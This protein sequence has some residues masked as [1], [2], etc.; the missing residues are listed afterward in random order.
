MFGGLKNT[1]AAAAGAAMGNQSNATTGPPHWQS[2]MCDC[3]DDTNVVLQTWC[4][5]PCTVSNIISYLEERKPMFDCMNCF[6][7]TIAVYATG[8]QAA[9]WFTYGLRN[10]II[11]R[12]GIQNEDY[13]NACMISTFCTPCALCQVQREMAKRNEHPGGFCAT[14]PASGVA[15]GIASRVAGEAAGRAGLG[16]AS[17][18]LGNSAWGT[19]LFDM[20]G[21]EC[22]ESFFCLCTLHGYSATKTVATRGIR[23]FTALDQAGGVLGGIAA[24]ASSALGGSQPGQAAAP[25][26]PQG[27]GE[28]DVPACL[29]GLVMPMGL[30]Y[31]HRRELVERYGIA[32]ESHILS[33]LVSIFCSCCAQS[34]QRREMGYRGQWPGGLCVKALPPRRQEGVRM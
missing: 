9:A 28:L 26:Q 33:G 19:G 11:S 5:H 29:A 12:Y 10:Q 8:F 25:P 24:R 20:T 18:L 23:Q 27:E 16:G 21:M 31:A 13:C 17:G 6:V 4:C 7:Y 34:Q 1:V 3:F 22:L 30:T 15:L 32:H 14:P 2:E